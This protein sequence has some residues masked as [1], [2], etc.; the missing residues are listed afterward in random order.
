MEMYYQKKLLSLANNSVETC[1]G[2]RFQG[3]NA[4]TV[5]RQ[6]IKATENGWY[7]VQSQTSR[8]EYYT[9]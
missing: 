1:V 3:L 7:T 5:A 4:H 2:I 6:G 9:L 8:G